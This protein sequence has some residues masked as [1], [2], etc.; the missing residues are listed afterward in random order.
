MTTKEARDIY[1][2]SD[3][4]YF[5]MCT[6][7]YTSYIEYKKL[8]LPSELENFW[9]DEKI[10]ALAV[11]IR[12]NGDYRLFNKMYDI[13]VEFRDYEK[14]RILLDALRRIS[15]PLTYKQCLS[16]AET[17]LGR[18][19]P[20]VRSGMIFWAYDIGQKGIAILLMDLALECLYMPGMSEAD[21]EK[22]VQKA[23]KL[24]KRIIAELGLHFSNRYLMHY[25]NF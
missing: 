17:I 8:G 7:Y 15:E 24:C 19:Y 25:Y 6:N 5:V 10:Q 13:A 14:L 16:I 20:K 12:L 3:C 18:K 2:K 11:E 21:C 23:Q 22:K 9:K 1:M 4:S